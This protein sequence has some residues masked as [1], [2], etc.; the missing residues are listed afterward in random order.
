MKSIGG[1][2]AI[3]SPRVKECKSC[4]SDFYPRQIAQSGERRQ[5]I[6][7]LFIIAADDNQ[8]E[9]CRPRPVPGA[10]L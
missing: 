7:L 8:P 3:F 10:W 4:H 1:S 6:E 2:D 9:I 5:D